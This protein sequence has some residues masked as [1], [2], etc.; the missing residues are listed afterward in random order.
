MV[1]I[2]VAAV[3]IIVWAAF[4]SI[5]ASV[6]PL[7]GPK[8]VATTVLILA[9][10]IQRINGVQRWLSK[11]KRSRKEQTDV[12]VQ[13]T[14]IDICLNRTVSREL[15]DLS[16]HVW[17]VPLWYRRVLPYALRTAWKRVIARWIFRI[18][19]RWILRPTLRR[20]V[21]LGLVK[22]APSGIRF[23]KGLGLIGVCIANNDRSEFITLNT[24]SRKYQRVLNSS[25]ESEW[26]QHGHEITHNL[27]L[28]DARKLSNSY[29]Q[30]IAKVIQ[31]MDSGEA[32]G[33]VTISVKGSSTTTLDIA[34]DEMFKSS[35]TTLAAS[36][37]RILA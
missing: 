3:A 16:V 10:T 34:G 12:L 24:S 19:A 23:R 2:V 8:F 33:C 5:S 37:A 13:Q 9:V 36:V 28:E 7:S 15:L 17:E 35:V 18:F 1:L 11:P 27:H 26:Q 4:I 14:L 22:Q 29:G 6:Q 31:D 25:S 20:V 32:I 21:A 30:V